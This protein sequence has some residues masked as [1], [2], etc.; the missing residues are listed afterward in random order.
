VWEEPLEAKKK[1]DIIFFFK[2]HLSITYL[3]NFRSNVKKKKNC[4]KQ[5]PFL[6]PIIYFLANMKSCLTQT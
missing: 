6:G 2:N 5:I 1:N 4:C 3:I